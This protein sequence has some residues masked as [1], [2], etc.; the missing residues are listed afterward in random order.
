[1]SEPP[2]PFAGDGDPLQTTEGR[3]VRGALR[4]NWPA[5]GA[6]VCIVAL[7]AGFYHEH[8]RGRPVPFVE[9]MGPVDWLLGVSLVVGAALVASLARRPERSR[10]YA[11]RLRDRPVALA[12]LGATGF[13]FVVGLAGPVFVSEPTEIVFTRAWVPPVGATVDTQFLTGECPGPVTDGRCRGTL[14]FPLG[15]TRDG[16]S[17]FPLVVLGARTAVEI[18]TVTTFVL[19]PVGVVV[20]LVSGTVG[21]RVDAVLMRVAEVFAT[22]PAVVLYLLFWSWNA[23]YRLLALALAF[24]LVNWGALARAVR[25]ETLELRERSFVQAA[26]LAGATRWALVRRHFLPNVSRQVL[27]TLALQVPLLVVTE[28]ALS[29][30]VLPVEGGEGTLGDPTVVSWGQLIFVGVRVDGLV[31]AWWITFFPTAALV[32]ATLSLAVALRSLGDVFAPVR[33]R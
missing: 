12:S 33:G 3:T 1:M 27:S 5:A 11:R 6:M 8:V 22:V 21:G 16:R 10:I 24:G 23:E 14:E 15:T 13:L 19:V 25:N 7:L 2:S 26:R 20:G 28:A 29:F 17:L 9:A 32:L 30:V 4:R 31:P 18:V